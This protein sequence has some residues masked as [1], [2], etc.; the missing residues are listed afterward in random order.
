MLMGKF[1]PTVHREALSSFWEK[2]QKNSILPIY[3]LKLKFSYG[4]TIFSDI[5]INKNYEILPISSIL[6]KNTE[7]LIKEN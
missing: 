5:Y 4:V 3:L 2:L 7:L 1:P 6:T